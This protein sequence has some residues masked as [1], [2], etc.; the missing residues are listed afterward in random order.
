MTIDADGERETRRVGPGELFLAFAGISLMGFGGVLPWVRWMI[1]ERRRW[2]VEEEFV[3]ALSLCQL[4]PGGNVMNIAVYV[5]ARFGGL[6]GALSALAGLLLVPCLIV[7]GL[8]GLYQAYGDLPSV[9]GMFRAVSATAAGLIL[10]MGLRIAWR[11][12]K[13][14]RALPV[15]AATILAMAWFKLPLLWILATILPASLLLV[16]LT[17]PR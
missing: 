12:R 6:L 2:M 8:G 17:R 9:Q 13:D 14:V 3:N 10:G 11:Y 16:V 7:I 1:V 15:M 5:G 4:I